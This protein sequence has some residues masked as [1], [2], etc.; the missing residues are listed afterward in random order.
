MGGLAGEDLRAEGF[1]GLDG[2]EESLEGGVEKADE[3]IGERKIGP[4]GE[5]G[6]IADLW[7]EKE[8]E[9]V[10][11]GGGGV[12]HDGGRIQDGRFMSSF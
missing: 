1:E 10:A 5:G 8:G 12:G 2:F 4:L 9:Q 3:Q 7:I 6:E 11:V